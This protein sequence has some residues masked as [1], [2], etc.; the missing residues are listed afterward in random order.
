M[1]EDRDWESVARQLLRRVLTL[2]AGMVAAA[3]DAMVAGVRRDPD[4]IVGLLSRFCRMVSV[5][6]AAVVSIAG[7]RCIFQAGIGSE[8]PVSGEEMRSDDV[9]T[10]FRALQRQDSVSS[11]TPGVGWDYF[12]PLRNGAGDLV[13]ILMV[14]DTSTDRRFTAHEESLIVGLVDLLSTVLVTSTE[15]T[16]LSAYQMVDPATSLL[17]EQGWRRQAEAHVAAASAFEHDLFLVRIR[18]DRC[19]E[20][21]ELYGERAMDRVRKNIAR[22]VRS[23]AAL[24]QVVGL[25]DD[26]DIVIIGRGALVHG[27]RLGEEVRSRIKPAARVWC[28]T[29]EDGLVPSVSVGVTQLSP[30]GLHADNHPACSGMVEEGLGYAMVAVFDAQQRGGDAVADDFDSDLAIS[31]DSIDSPRVTRL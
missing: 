9:L 20:L 29:Q 12:R 23:L 25:M 10:A 17:N 7:G 2:E 21:V 27:H 30:R 5:D 19:D 31:L 4:A 26:R 24:Y 3:R 15:L 1:S 8:L 11:P 16:M 6:R 13:G 14:D 18:L 28:R 22:F